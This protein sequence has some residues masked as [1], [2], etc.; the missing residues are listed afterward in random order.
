MTI[1]PER[2]AELRRLTVDRWLMGATD[3]HCKGCG[4]L[5]SLCECDVKLGQAVPELLDEIDRLRAVI[6][7]T[8]D[9]R[10]CGGGMH[11]HTCKLYE[12]EP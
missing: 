12:I 10:S 5:G 9:P 8:C 4:K 1:I 6:R 2:L 3:W 11:S 7:E